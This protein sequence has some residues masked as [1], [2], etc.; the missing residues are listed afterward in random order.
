MMGPIR[1]ERNTVVKLGNSKNAD[2]IFFRELREQLSKL[3][4][5]IQY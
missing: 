1:F 5:Q 2:L 3:K 4:D